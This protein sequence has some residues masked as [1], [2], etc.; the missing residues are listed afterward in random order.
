MVIAPL[1]SR[2]WTVFERKKTCDAKKEKLT[3]IFLGQVDGIRHIS[4]NAGGGLRS[5]GF[6]RPG[7]EGNVQGG[8][9][10]VC[11]LLQ[12]TRVEHVPR[13]RHALARVLGMRTH[14][15][16]R[17]YGVIEHGVRVRY[18]R[19]DGAL[20]WR[21]LSSGIWRRCPPAATRAG[22][23]PQGCWSD[24]HGDGHYSPCGARGLPRGHGRLCHAGGVVDQ[25]H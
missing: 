21:A 17:G 20:T 10:G 3:A 6:A 16:T 12:G 23:I 1:L 7:G 11:V 2:R 18:A 14:D 5:N 25:L 24:G 15:G 8:V 9:L 22:A 19:G 4:P 13:A